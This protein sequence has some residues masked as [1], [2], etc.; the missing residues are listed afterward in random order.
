MIKTR[1]HIGKLVPAR[2]VHVGN[3]R[4]VILEDSLVEEYQELGRFVSYTEGYEKRGDLAAL[5]SLRLTL[6]TSSG[7]LSNAAACSCS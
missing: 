7:T 4:Q 6:L 5:I 2:L 1:T 3:G